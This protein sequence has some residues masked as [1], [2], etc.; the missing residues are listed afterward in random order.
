MGASAIYEWVNILLRDGEAI[1]ADTISANLLTRIFRAAVAEGASRP[2]LLASIGLNEARLRN[3]LNRLSS[4]VALRTFRVLERHFADPA[5]TLRIGQQA[6]MQNFSDLGYATRLSNNLATV[7]DAN[8]R[9]QILRQNMVTTSFAPAAKPPTLSWNIGLGNVSEFAPFVEFSVA[10]F[11]RL[12]SQILGESPLLRRVDFAHPA[13]FDPEIYERVFG[14]QVYFSMPETKMEMT[15]RQ[16][17]RPSIHADPALLAAATQRYGQPANWMADGK[18][19]T[20]VSYFY[21]SNEIDKSPPTLDRMAASFGMTERSLRRKLV[22]EGQP[23]RKLLD[24]V[25][26]DLCTLYFLE[27]K[28]SLGE[29]ALLLGYGELSAFTRAYKRWYNVAPSK[30]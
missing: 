30:A 23:F 6:T 27:D 25:R 24:H 19:H 14:C 29:I 21:L 4:Q 1:P 7:I 17:F 10:T 2:S 3:P 18:Q 5:I 28:R 8:I 26:R 15:A 11:A 16:L 12:S 20:A 13:R 22:N 9:I